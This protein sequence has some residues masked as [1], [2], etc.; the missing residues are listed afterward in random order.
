[1]AKLRNFRIWGKKD[2]PLESVIQASDLPKMTAPDYFAYLETLRTDL[3]EQVLRKS[4]SDKTLPRTTTRKTDEAINTFVQEVTNN[5]D[6]VLASV[7]G[8][9]SATPSLGDGQDLWEYHGDSST[10]RQS[11]DS[12]TLNIGHW[13]GQITTSKEPQKGLPN[14]GASVKQ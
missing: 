7:A 3:R 11:R 1:M 5:I 6:A 8:T 2:F 12:S 14:P 9:E 4:F 10:R 13:T